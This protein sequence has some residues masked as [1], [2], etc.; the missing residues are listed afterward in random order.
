M[1]TNSKDKEL[2]DAMKDVLRRQGYAYATEKP[3]AIG[4]DAKWGSIS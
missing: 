3:I 2:L 1:N 4:W